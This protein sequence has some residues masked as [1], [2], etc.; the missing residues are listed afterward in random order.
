MIKQ[1]LL[2]CTT[3][4]I[5]AAVA[6]AQTVAV[7]P[8]PPTPPSPPSS[9]S[10]TRTFKAG[11][12]YLGVMLEDVD[13]ENREE[14]GARDASGAV[15][16]SVTVGS[17]ASGAGLRQ[18][19]IVVAFNGT[20][21]NDAEHLSRLVRETPGEQSVKLEVL[22]SGSVT[23]IDVVLGKRKVTIAESFRMPTDFDFGTIDSINGH[24]RIM[25]QGLDSM[26]RAL[27][28][29][30]QR[31]DFSQHFNLPDNHQV[32]V[33][34]H[35]GRLGAEL[36][37]L[38]GQLAKYFGVSSQK[39]VLVSTVGDSGAARSA[40]LQAGD[41]IVSIDGKEVWSPDELTRIVGARKE[42]DVA[43]RIVRDRREQ[44]VR[45]SLPKSVSTWFNSGGAE[46]MQFFN[47]EN[48][49]R[50]FNN[51]E[52]MV[53]FNDDMK[54]LEIDMKELNEDL[55]ELRENL[56][57]MEIEHDVDVDVKIDVDEHSED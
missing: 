41:V 18:K 38:T 32:R 2:I 48:M 17:P 40:G 19:D 47:S 20:K 57:E 27:G 12:G 39:G 36:Q 4:F 15:I 33:F 1:L 49:Q 9:H 11:G 35:R 26:C 24:L 16:T 5:L 56:E 21:V 55:Q 42:G 51:E 8:T 44:T 30:L 23:T 34:T 37:P 3:S 46:S 54:D 45:V 13:S 29:S 28:D 7:P 22:R 14:L 52:G 43:M 50:F 31:M 25:T 10:W 6:N 53:F